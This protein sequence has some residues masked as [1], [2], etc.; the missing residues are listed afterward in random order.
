L[1]TSTRMFQVLFLNSS[2]QQCGAAGVGMR[3]RSGVSR[4]T[5]VAYT[6]LKCVLTKLFIAE[7][8]LKP[9]EHGRG[10]DVMVIDGTVDC[11]KWQVRLI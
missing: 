5:T 8:G 4:S 1:V 6:S 2:T 3:F 9:V 7:L 10:E 11:A